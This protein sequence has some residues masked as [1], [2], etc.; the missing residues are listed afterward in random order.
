MTK[1]NLLITLLIS[2][3]ILLIPFIAMQV[4]S[5][6]NWQLMDF[7]IG[8]VLAF[9]AGVSVNL[10][11]AKIAKRNHRIL[12]LLIVFFVFALIWAELA[13]GVFGTPFAGS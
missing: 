8:F 11:W 10:V 2:L 7:I 6:V 1:K 9:G 3:G 4:T 5:E 13:V 12:L